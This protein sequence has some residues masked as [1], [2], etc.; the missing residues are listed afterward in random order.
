MTRP[1]DPSSSTHGGSLD[2]AYYEALGRAIQVLRV[3]RGLARKEL[4]EASG[5]SYPYLSEIENG[6]KRP[7][8]ESL[9]A[10]ANALEMRPSELMERAESYRGTA[11]AEPH[12]PRFEGM[13]PSHEWTQPVMSD[14][15]HL[16]SGPSQPAPAPAP[17][18][19]QTWVRMASA[20]S[21][22]SPPAVSSKR[23]RRGSARSETDPLAE[24]IELA[25]RLAP[26]D[27]DR[28]I[29]LARRLAR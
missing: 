11:P 25:R 12:N 10:I 7:S 24:L 27:V 22:S 6:K 17:P 14:A 21:S 9:L 19:A 4:A 8:S 18:P 16:P 3:E 20:S 5:V 1:S 15:L 23:S 29:E 13:A 28:L 26:E 2:P